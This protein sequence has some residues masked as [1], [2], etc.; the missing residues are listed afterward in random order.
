[1]YPLKV[2]LHQKIKSLWVTIGNDPGKNLYWNI[3][4][5]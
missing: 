5:N 3:D 2:H 4:L 1:M